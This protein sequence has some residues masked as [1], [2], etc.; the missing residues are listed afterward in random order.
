VSVVQI[1]SNLVRE[2]VSRIIRRAHLVL[3]ICYVLRCEQLI[4]HIKDDTV[5]IILYRMF[6]K[7]GHLTLYP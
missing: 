2:A 5:D 4:Y 3:V 6:R 7:L 1:T